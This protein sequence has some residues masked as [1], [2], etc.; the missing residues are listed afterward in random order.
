MKF[1]MKLIDPCVR[2]VL[3]K[4][5]QSGFTLI[6]LMVVI[7]SIAVLA[8]VTA[9]NF[10]NYLQE[11]GL[12]QAVYQISGDLHRT[13]SQAIRTRIVQ[14]MNFSQVANNYVCSNPL[15]TINLADFWGSV[16]YTNNPDGGLDAFSPTIAFNTRGLSGLVPAVTTQVYLTN[17]VAGPLGIGNGRI[18]RV[19]VSAAGAVSIHEWRGGRWIQ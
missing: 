12:K 19:Q 2:R 5:S 13:K 17:Q 1:F 9:P 16:V 3:K 15:H 7:A 8:G 11:A 4:Q 18:F 14:T 6:E 10:I